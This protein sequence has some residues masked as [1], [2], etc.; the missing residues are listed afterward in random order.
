MRSDE[1]VDERIDE[2][3]VLRRFGNVERM[4]NDRFAK[5]VYVGECA[6][7]RSVGRLWKIWIDNVKY[8][9]KKKLCDVRQAKRMVQD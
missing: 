4:E 7:S 1:G 8:C 3:V 5:R 6:D 9:L 2:G